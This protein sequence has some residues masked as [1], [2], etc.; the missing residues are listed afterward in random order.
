[1]S[2][3]S[4]EERPEISPV[5]QRCLI[6]LQ[7]YLQ[8]RRTRDEGRVPYLTTISV[9]EAMYLLPELIDENENGEKE[10]NSVDKSYTIDVH[11]LL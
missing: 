5:S 11:G 2:T 3:T 1:M 10:Q 6:S 4:Y 9:Y 7:Q 8:G